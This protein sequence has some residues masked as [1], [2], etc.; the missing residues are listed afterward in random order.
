[1]SNNWQKVRLSEICKIIS[2]STPRTSEPLYWNGEIGWVTPYDLSKLKDKYISN[3][4]RNITELG[5]KRC[6]AELLPAN[7]L[8]MSSR[9]PIGYFAINKKPVATNQGCKSFICD[10]SIDTEFLYYSL[11]QVIDSIKKV[12]SG[13]TFAEVGKSSLEKI[14]ILVPK[15]SVQQK[16]ALILS[17]V[18]EEIQ[19]TD[20]I[21]EKTEKLKNGLMGELLTRGIGHTKYVKTK[22]GEIPKEWKIENLS[23]ICDVRDGTHDS[24]KYISEGYPLITSKNLTEYG[25]D[26]SDIKYIS[27]TDY[28]NISKRSK[29]DIGDILFGMIGTIGKPIIVDSIKEFSIKNVALIKFFDNSPIDR[30]YLLHYL[31]SY[32]IAKQF[33]KMQ[34][35]STQKFIS[36]GTIR[37]L[38]ILLPS[39]EEQNK[40]SSIIESI[41]KKIISNTSQKKQ[42]IKLKNSLMNDI[43]SQK[44]EVKN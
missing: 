35:G 13:S 40:I 31:K 10:D 22:F 5:L 11:N 29:V 17:C 42:L 32:L 34:D 6:S 25:L 27:E 14:S 15:K 8:I 23:N 9:A 28:K 7:S 1:M 41:D 19:K 39:I 16:I 24:P 3:G 36:L 33:A 30:K 21:I 26:F 4:S 38:T 37:N 2:G 43:F 18:D 12:G 44:V 20:Q